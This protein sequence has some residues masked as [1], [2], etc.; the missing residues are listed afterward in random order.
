MIDLNKRTVEIQITGNTVWVNVDGECLLRVQ[1]CDGIS[2]DDMRSRSELSMQT[3]VL[4]PEEARRILEI[5][6]NGEA[7]PVLPGLT[8]KQ[9]NPD[10]LNETLLTE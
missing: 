5:F 8:F 7:K 4:S 2:V 1:D 10:S 6:G 3:Q 9:Y